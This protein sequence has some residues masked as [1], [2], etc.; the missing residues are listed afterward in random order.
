MVFALETFWPAYRRLDRRPHRGGARRDGRRAARSSRASRPKSCS[1]PGSTTTRS[2][3]RWRRS[4]R[5]S[6]TST[7]ATAHRRCRKAITPSRR[8]EVATDVIMPALGVA[9]DTGRVV[10]WLYGEGD[11]VTKHQPLIEIET[12]KVTVELEA[13]ADG[14]LA[15]VTA[16]PGDDVAVGTVI[17]LILAP[18]EALSRTSE[19]L[20]GR[21]PA[22]PVAR[23]MAR[24]LGIDLAVARTSPRAPRP[25]ERRASGCR[26]RATRDRSRR[27][28]RRCRTARRRPSAMPGARWPSGRLPA[29]QRRRTSR[30]NG[31]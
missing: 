4:A 14:T 12:D 15:A 16:S 5:P 26:R 17:A 6:R 21:A 24:D 23:R 8:A 3:V 30:C 10:R 7:E 31:R 20:P 11:A 13:P 19:P 18:G 2:A 1:S 9:Q 28:A 22:S 25:G 29:G 27:R